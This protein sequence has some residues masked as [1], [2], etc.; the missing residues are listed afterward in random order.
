MNWF[1]EL[2]LAVS[3]LTRLPVS[4]PP[5]HD[6]VL[7]ARSAAWFPAVGLLI[8][9]V[10]VLTAG[11]SALVFS[12]SITAMLIL[13]TDALVTGALHLDG[14]ADSADGLGGAWDRRRVLEVMRDH[15]IGAYGAAALVLVLGLKWAVLAEVVAQPRA[16][17]ILLV[18]PVLGRWA[19]VC[20]SAA[21]PYARATETSVGYMSAHIGWREW[22]FATISS[23]TASVW[24]L[25]GPGA[26]AL[27]AAGATA[28]VWGFY[29]MHRIGGV[30]GDTI[31]AVIVISEVVVMTFTLV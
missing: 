4:Q 24:L 2:R 6:S 8:G 11:T 28:L 29:L 3:F 22:T 23:A 14:L 10:H 26:V 13:V 18:A 31:G 15:A 30:T 16:I 5:V 7:L 21:L 1:R 27:V 25:G 20:L 9:S 12:P 19:G 17:P